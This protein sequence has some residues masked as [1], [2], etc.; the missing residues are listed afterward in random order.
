[1]QWLFD[2]LVAPAIAAIG[3]WFRKAIWETIKFGWWIYRAPPAIKAALYLGSYSIVL[4]TLAEMR[5]DGALSPKAVAAVDRWR[6]YWD[7]R[8]MPKL[9]AMAAVP[10]PSPRKGFFDPIA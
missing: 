3:I 5:A 1:M 2:W 9:E 8:A 4:R 6:E 7:R 10:L